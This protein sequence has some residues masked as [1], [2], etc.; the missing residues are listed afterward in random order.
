V[1]APPSPYPSWQEQRKVYSCRYELTCDAVRFLALRYDE[2]PHP[3]VLDVFDVKGGVLEFRT[4][5]D[6]H[7]LFVILDQVH[8]SHVMEQTLC[9]VPLADNSLERLSREP[10]PT[11][12]AR[13]GNGESMTPVPRSAAAGAR[14]GAGA[15][16]LGASERNLV[17]TSRT[18]WSFESTI[19]EQKDA[20]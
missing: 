8:D 6:L 13:L 4:P 20:V 15:L 19:W 17:R 14:R 5:L 12:R 10:W 3:F 18:R 2:V 11:A 7:A 16:H 9:P 1:G